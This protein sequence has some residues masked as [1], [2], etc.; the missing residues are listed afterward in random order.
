MLQGATGCYTPWPEGRPQATQLKG[1]KR[2]KQLIEEKPSATKRLDKGGGILSGVHLSV[3][4]S[5]PAKNGEIFRRNPSEKRQ[6][7][8]R[9]PSGEPPG[10]SPLKT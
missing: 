4:P 7:K 6:R 8:V 2:L 1:L 9:D 5:G 10:A 3:N